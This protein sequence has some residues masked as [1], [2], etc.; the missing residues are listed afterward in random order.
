[1]YHLQWVSRSYQIACCSVQDFN[2]AWI[3]VHCYI[4]EQRVNYNSERGSESKCKP[5]A[6][7]I[8]NVRGF[9]RGHLYLESRNAATSETSQTK[10]SGVWLRRLNM[11]EYSRVVYVTP[12]GLLTVPDADGICRNS[13]ILRKMWQCGMSV[14]QSMQK[15]RHA[16]F[17]TLK[18][19]T[20]NK[21]VYAVKWHYFVTTM[22]I[23]QA[24]T[25][26]TMR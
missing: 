25:N 26:C 5:P 10:N 9:K 22:N 14:S 24:C 3:T 2:F 20:K 23:S 11:D 7:G 1:M 16:H 15:T 13:K 12:G 4:M 8:K 19:M 17:H 6:G 21:S 18:Y